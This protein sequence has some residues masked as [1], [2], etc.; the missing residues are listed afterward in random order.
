[1][2]YG[3]SRLANVH[4]LLVT[5]VERVGAGMDVNVAQGARPVEDEQ[6][7]IDAGRSH[8]KDPWDS[9]HVIGPKRPLAEAV[10]LTFYPVDWNDHQAFVR[11]AD[12]VKATAQEL[13]ITI[14]WGGDWA[15]PFD[16]DHFELGAGPS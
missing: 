2:L 13:G 16:F 12:V 1:M 7:D 14:S 11:L 10:D 6:A 4:P 8:L 15:R 5:L 3:R 9:K